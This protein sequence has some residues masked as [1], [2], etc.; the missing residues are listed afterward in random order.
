MLVRP[1]LIHTKLN[2]T[3]QGMS[4]SLKCHS[5]STRNSTI[6][7]SKEVP[8]ETNPHFF[9]FQ[10]VT[11]FERWFSKPR[12]QR[13]YENGSWELNAIRWSRLTSFESLPWFL[14]SQFSFCYN[15]L[16]VLILTYTYVF[17]LFSVL[18]DLPTFFPN[19]F[20]NSKHSN[21]NLYSVITLS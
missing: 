7:V 13:L 12:S 16:Y 14:N 6:T 20:Q 21:L 4:R 9:L 2:T 10:I 8:M 3:T 17:P 11:D 15:T 1:F 5:D 19:F 18:T